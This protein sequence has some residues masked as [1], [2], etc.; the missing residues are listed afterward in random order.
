MP[1]DAGRSVADYR[2]IAADYDRATRRINRIRRE[3]VDVLSLRPGETVMDIGFG[4][5]FSFEPIIGAIGPSGWLLAFDHSPELLEIARGRIAAAG[6][7]NVVLLETN[8]ENADFRPH[9][10]ARGIRAP[11]ALLFSYV[12]DI[13]QS[14]PALDN[15]LGQASSGA[16]VAACGT[17]LWPRWGAPVNMYLYITHRHYISNRR[18]NFHMPWVKF[19]CRVETFRVSVRRPPGWR[20]MATGTLRKRAPRLDKKS[21][22]VKAH[23]LKPTIC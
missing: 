20:Y 1:A 6:W 2:A 9:M 18:E 23:T 5:G 16:R 17:K 3:T 21:P 4:S 13:L 7:R 12:H 11:S 22:F 15:L 10:T 14:E 8:A 19:A